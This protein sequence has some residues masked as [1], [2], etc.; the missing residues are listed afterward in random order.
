MTLISDA[1]SAVAQS[2][3][4]GWRIWLLIPS[5]VIAVCC[6]KLGDART[7]TEHEIYVAG[8]AKQMASDHDWLFPRFGDHFWLEKPPLLHCLTIVSAKL[9]DF[10]KQQCGY[11]PSSPVWVSS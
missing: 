11:P 8:G 1:R 6:F 3:S 7:L 2:S 4:L 9:L 10:P 5:V